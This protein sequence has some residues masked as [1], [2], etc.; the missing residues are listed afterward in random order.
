AFV[1][2]YLA[3][4]QTVQTG[5]AADQVFI[6]D[7]SNPAAPVVKST[8]T[9]SS[10]TNHVRDIKASGNLLFVAD[11]GLRILQ[12]NA[13]GSNTVIKTLATSDFPTM[14][15]SNSNRVAV[16]GQTAFVVQGGSVW[17]VDISIPSAARV[18]PTRTD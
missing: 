5:T 18:Y 11:T 12:I 4:R 14:G 8:F 10:S 1:G 15:T 13:D 17:P 2:N 9:E 7:V 6:M 16:G 3:V